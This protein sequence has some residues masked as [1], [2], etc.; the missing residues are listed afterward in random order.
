MAISGAYNS[1]RGSSCKIGFIRK[2]T[3]WF[4]V[5]SVHSGYENTVVTITR[6][7]GCATWY[8]RGNGTRLSRV[9][10]KVNEHCPRV[11]SAANP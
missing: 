11:P 4:S 3:G 1:D 8:K 6:G 9:S 10:R 2:D 7:G 5:H